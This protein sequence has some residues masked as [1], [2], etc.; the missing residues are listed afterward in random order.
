MTTPVSLSDVA[1]VFLNLFEV[2]DTRKSN[3]SGSLV[4]S[5][6]SSFANG[7]AGAGAAGAAAAATA[8]T[9]PPRF[10]ASDLYGAS[11]RPRE[12]D[13]KQDAIGDCYYVATLGAIAERTPARI[14]DA[15]SYDPSTGNFKV[16]LY[17]NEWSWSPLGYK[18][19][20]IEVT[21]Q[22][23]LDNLSRRGGS[24]VDNNPGTDSPIWPAVMETAYAKMNDSNWSDGL[25]QGY[26]KITGGWAKDAMRAVTGDSGDVLTGMQMFDTKTQAEVL[27]MQVS[28]AMND[29][30][31]VT[32]STDPERPGFWDDVV[33]L[34][35]QDGLIDNHV[36]MVD[37]IYKNANGDVMVELRNP[38]GNN[39]NAGEGVNTPSATVTVKLE[40]LLQTKGLECFNV[41]PK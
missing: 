41:G 36:Y 10:D 15:I 18:Q 25:T 9:T 4:E 33:G 6:L 19:V 39:N 8:P 2:T 11:G 17:T 7:A 5:L 28:S 34:P 24:I 37:R 23:I 31:P 13:I 26:Q 3:A 38:W 20:T 35:T 27:Y 14:K 30:R 22:D 29:G 12:A 21:Q 32:L 1:D 16:K 40:T